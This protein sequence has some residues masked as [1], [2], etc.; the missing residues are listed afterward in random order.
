[1]TKDEA[2]T[3]LRW[4][5]AAFPMWMAKLDVKDRTTTYAIYER[6]LAPLPF[7]ST[8]DRVGSYERVKKLCLG[9]GRTNEARPFAPSL[10][11]LMA[12]LGVDSDASIALHAKAMHDGGHLHRDPYNPASIDGWVYTPKGLPT[13]TVQA[14]L[15]PAA[16]ATAQDYTRP[17][18]TQ[19]RYALDRRQSGVYRGRQRGPV[20]LG[21]ALPAVPARPET[22]AEAVG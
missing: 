11:E 8:P 4:I 15:P 21:E 2:K 12:V 9:A 22:S 3:C 10:P 20:K 19:N 17:T 7:E 16:P 13:P 18:P 1:M 6:A 14:Q 5:V